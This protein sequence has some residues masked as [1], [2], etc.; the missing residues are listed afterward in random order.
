MP[1]GRT[2]PDPFGWFEGPLRQPRPLRA[3]AQ[4]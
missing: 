1:A 3:E 4:R 2:D